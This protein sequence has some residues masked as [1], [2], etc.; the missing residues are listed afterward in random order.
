L[1]PDSRRSKPHA[2]ARG[3]AWSAAAARGVARD[4]AWSGGWWS[5][6]RGFGRDD[7]LSAMAGVVR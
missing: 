5:I 4:G 1:E 3:G 7:D 2:P 6:R